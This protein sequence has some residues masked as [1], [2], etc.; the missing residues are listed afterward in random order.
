M[1]ESFAPTHIASSF[2]QA[3]AILLDQLAG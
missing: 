2:G 1:Q 3:A